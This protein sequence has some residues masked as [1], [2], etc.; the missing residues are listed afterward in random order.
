MSDSGPIIQDVVK[1]IIQPLVNSIIKSPPP[2]APLWILEN[3][4]WNDQ[5]IWDDSE[6]WND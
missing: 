4:I 3:N 2:P 6:T 1:L 5:G